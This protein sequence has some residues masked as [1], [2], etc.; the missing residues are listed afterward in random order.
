MRVTPVIVTLVRGERHAVTI[1]QKGY[2]PYQVRLEP[3]LSP[4]IFGNIVFGGLI[5]LGVDAITGGMYEYRIGQIHAFF[6]TAVQEQ[7]STATRSVTEA[8]TPPVVAG[9][10]TRIVREC[11]PYFRH[12]VGVRVATET[13]PLRVEPYAAQ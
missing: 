11:D 4:F 7:P 5:G 2:T 8:T 3:T 1:E 12:P 9:G 6:P 13:P 10:S